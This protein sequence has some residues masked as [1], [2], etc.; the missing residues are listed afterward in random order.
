MISDSLYQ[1]HDAT[2]GFTGGNDSLHAYREQPS[3]K[4]KRP[5]VDSPLRLANTSPYG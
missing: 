4:T 2:R 1:D 3:P 5:G